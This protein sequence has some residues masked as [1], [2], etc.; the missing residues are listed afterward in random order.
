MLERLFKKNRSDTKYKK[1]IVVIGFNKTGTT[2]IHRLFQAS[3]FKSVHWDE[4]KLTRAMLENAI[5]SRPILEGY[6]DRF[7]VFSDLVFRSDC[8]WFEGN[9]LFKQIDQQYQNA[10]F[11]Y[12]TRN[13]D[14]WVDSRCKHAQQ[15]E[16]HTVLSLHKKILDTDDIEKVK[17]HWKAVR[18]NYESELDAYFA[19][20]S[21]LLKIDITDQDFTQKLSEFI[22]IELDPSQWGR[23]NKT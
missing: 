23:F 6:D 5:N 12:N 3:G 9:S 7:D 16:E 8:F 14:D 1:L 13:I 4:G 10:H 15:V 17:S 22:E 19:A 21:N 2:S 20:K 18:L 11:I